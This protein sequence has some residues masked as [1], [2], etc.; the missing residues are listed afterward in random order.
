[1]RISFRSVAIAVGVSAI[2]S[3]AGLASLS[4][5]PENENA[6]AEFVQRGA[7]SSIADQAVPRPPG[8]IGPEIE[9]GLTDDQPQ[10][11]EG[12]VE[13]LCSSS[14]REWRDRVGKPNLGSSTPGSYRG[15]KSLTP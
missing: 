14:A 1:M 15:L 5:P 13:V 8:A 9:L 3:L 12:E 4:R 7:A 11:W 10:N 6:E 2:L